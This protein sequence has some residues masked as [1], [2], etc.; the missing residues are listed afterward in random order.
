MGQ[1][2]YLSSCTTCRKI[3]EQLP[4]HSLELIDIKTS[5]PTAVQI[6]ELAAHAGSYS[7]IFSKKSMLYKSLNLK[8]EVLDEAAMRKYLLQHYTFLKRPVFYI[9]GKVF[10]GNSAAVIKDVHQA[11]Q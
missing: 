9:N 3:L 4:A 11:L 7:A 5:P 10:A 6:D 2:Y 8:D 1:V